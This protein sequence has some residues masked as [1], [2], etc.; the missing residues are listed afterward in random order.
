MPEKIDAPGSA[1]PTVWRK[2]LKSSRPAP[3]C[4]GGVLGGQG[5]G[6]ELGFGDEDG[7]LT[8][9]GVEAEAVAVGGLGGG[10]G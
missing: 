2:T 4:C 7:Q 9:V 6:G 1:V 8:G 3:N 10:V 5:A